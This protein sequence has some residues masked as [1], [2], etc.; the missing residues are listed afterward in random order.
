MSWV[1]ND[2]FVRLN[3]SPGFGA[4]SYIKLLLIY[5]FLNGQSIKT[6]IPVLLV[7]KLTFMRSLHSEH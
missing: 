4:G 7:T 2:L 3:R 6:I 5:V 1:A